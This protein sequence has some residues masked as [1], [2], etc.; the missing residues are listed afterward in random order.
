MV[1]LQKF[2]L[3]I[4]KSEKYFIKGRFYFIKILLLK[5]YYLLFYY[6]IYKIF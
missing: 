4:M 2:V 1:E 5:K 3:V 6:N